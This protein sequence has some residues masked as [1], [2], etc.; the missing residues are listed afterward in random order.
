MYRGKVM[1]FGR[2]TRAG[3]RANLL[4]AVHRAARYPSPQSSKAKVTSATIFDS[5]SPV[6]AAAAAASLAA[7]R[8]CPRWSW[9]VRL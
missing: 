5:R 2:I 6:D 4:E 9:N 1:S 7:A 8:R 3:E